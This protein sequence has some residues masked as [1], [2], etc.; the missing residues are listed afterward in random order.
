MQFRELIGV[1]PNLPPC[2]GGTSHLLMATPSSTTISRAR[3]FPFGKYVNNEIPSCF[4]H[5]RNGNLISFLIGPEFP[6]IALCVAFEPANH[7]G[8]Y[9]CHA[10]IS[11]NGSKQTTKNIMIKKIFC[12]EG[13]CFSCSSLQEL[14]EGFNL[15]DQNLVEIFCETSPHL[16]IK[17]IGVHVQCICP[18]PQKSSIFH[19]NYCIQ[20]RG[21][22][23]SKRNAHQRLRPSLLKGPNFILRR[24]YNTQYRSTPSTFLQPLLKARKISNK[25]R[26]LVAR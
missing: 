26:P 18:Q 9:Y 1:P 3:A 20:P 22:R 19:D 24:L 15:G 23:I 8:C 2:L 14:F 5:Q 21:R 13:M 7:L 6:T 10:I 25:K 17:R 11:I 12:Y 16:N 4:N